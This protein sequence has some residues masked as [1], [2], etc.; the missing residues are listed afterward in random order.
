MRLMPGNCCQAAGEAESM[1][2]ARHVAS[3]DSDDE[4]DELASSGTA[5]PFYGTDVAKRQA[6]SALHS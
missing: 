5:P 2:I 6:Q 1:G 3:A 4:E